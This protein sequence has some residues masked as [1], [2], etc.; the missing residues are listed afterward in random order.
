LVLGCSEGAGSFTVVVCD[1]GTNLLLEEVASLTFEIGSTVAYDRAKTEGAVKNGREEAS[2][3]EEDRRAA[4]VGKVTLSPRK[5]HEAAAIT[6][7]RA[8]QSIDSVYRVCRAESG[9]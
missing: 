8:L 4:M 7:L 2:K 6:Q 1:S 5:A 3:R 9:G